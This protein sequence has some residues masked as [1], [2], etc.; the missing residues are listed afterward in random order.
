MIALDSDVSNPF[1]AF[2]PVFGGLFSIL[3]GIVIIALAIATLLMP[4]V[5]WSI[6]DNVRTMRIR[7]E[8]EAAQRLAEARSHNL[9]QAQMLVELRAIHTA[10]AGA[11][12]EHESQTSPLQLPPIGRQSR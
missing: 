1:Q 6:R 9:H 7:E 4:F 11:T 2:G 10:L 8:S 3:A 5:I 12:V